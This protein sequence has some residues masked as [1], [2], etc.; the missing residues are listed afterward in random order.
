MPLPH[1]AL[2]PLALTCSFATAA[3]FKGHE[4]DW[5]I[6]SF[7][8]HTGEQL[9]DLNMHY[10]TV[11]NP[12]NPAVLYLHG[13]NRPGSDVLKSDFAG[14]LFGPGQALDTSKYYII[15]PDGIGI[16]KSSKPS[17]GL[18]MKFPA[19]NYTDLVNAQYRLLTEGLNIKHLR[20]VIG[21]SMGGMQT[22]L[23]GTD[24]PTMMDGLVPM[25]SQ[26]T[27]MA[28]RNWIMRKLL[29]ESIKQDPAWNNGNYSTQPPSLR[30]ANALFS[31]GTSGG[32]LGW[33]AV[34]PTHALADKQVE[35]KLALPLPGDAND[36]IY[37]WQASADY[38]PAPRLANIRVPLLVINSA[39]DERNPP[40]TNTLDVALKQLPSARLVLIPE[41]AD[42][43]GHGTTSYAKFYAEPLRE[44]MAK[45]P[46]KQ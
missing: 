8:F 23:W 18:R 13:T 31:V 20:L 43:R 14:E 42:T 40:E 37:Q 2:I 17:D 21:N 9:R 5:T 1:Y 12:K 33:Y 22:W 24:Y 3:D 28:S 6:P 27:E 45:L 10:V 39:D 4:A 44:F 30:L 15:A 38:N 7:T 25:A 19:Y 46:A 16:G 36:F 41:S 26:P 29:I 34:A 11:G 35:E 32:N